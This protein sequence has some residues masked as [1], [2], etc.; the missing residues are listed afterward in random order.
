LELANLQKQIP[1]A[2]PD[3]SEALLVAAIRRVSLRSPNKV[4][5]HCMSIMLPPLGVS[6]IRIRFIPE[7][8]HSAVFTTQN[9][10]KER[11][12]PVAFS[13][14]IV[15]TNMF[16]APSI[17]VGASQV[18]MGPVQ[19]VMEAPMPKTGITGYMGALERPL[20]D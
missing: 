17:T 11:E 13:P 20:I 14:W 4:G 3:E 18:Q 12:L 2:S 10:I 7:V 19:I 16:F 15:G 8:D 6:P 1:A 5:T 9:P